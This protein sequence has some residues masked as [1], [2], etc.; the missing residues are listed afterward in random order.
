MN[1]ITIERLGE[2]LKD[3]LLHTPEGVRDL[4]GKELEKKAELEKILHETISS[5]GY[6]DIQTPGFEFFDVFSKEIGT[7]P[8]NELYKFFDKEGNTMVLRPDFT[9]SIAR[10]A[11][12]YFLDENMPLRFTYI[13]NAYNNTGELQG[14]LKETTQL[15]AEL[16]NDD[17]VYADAEMIS[18]VIHGLLKTGLRDFQVTIGDA[19]YFK[20]LCMQL[21]L[22]D[23]QVSTLRRL[24][25]NK[26]YFAAQEY[27]EKEQ[28]NEIVN[29]PLLLLEE[30]IGEK[31]ILERALLPVQNEMS[32]NAVLRLQ[33]LYSIL[34]QYGVEQYVLFD[35]GMLSKYQYYTGMIYKVYTYGIGDAIVTG[36][37]YNNLL[38]QF[39]KS[40]PAVGFVCIIDDILKALNHQNIQIFTN[41]KKKIVLY[42][43]E[44]FKQAL[45]KAE[46]LRNSGV[47][48]ELIEFNEK[49]SDYSYEAYEKRIGADE[50]IRY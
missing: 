30:Y 40:A 19:S 34:Q 11:A 18:L 22:T 47:C 28:A 6:Q 43:K 32:K 13:G 1:C 23:E 33:N 20:G 29:N 45:H 4:Y 26:N 50:I 24:I 16:I 15:G 37:R 44:C 7:T 46:E 42:K 14:K 48:C 5:Y 35:L 41:K 39:G 49:I 36:G 31:E 9:P 38:S 10:C 25:S 12:K 27:L 2:G 17:S 8:S 21:H 3:N